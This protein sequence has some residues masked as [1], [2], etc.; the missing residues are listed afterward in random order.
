MIELR[1]DTGDIKNLLKTLKVLPNGLEKATARAINRTLTSTRAHMVKL[2]REDYAVKAGA[3]RSSLAIQK[4][5]WGNLTG[6]IHGAGPPGIPLLEFVRGSKKAP[7]TR[8]LKSGGYRPLVG[9]PVIVRKDKGKMPAKGVF[10]ARMKSGHV[11][12]F[13]RTVQ[14][15]GARRLT[16]LGNRYIKEAYGPSPLKIL[17]SARYDGQIEDFAEETMRKNLQHEAEY[18]LKQ[19]GLR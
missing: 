6:R 19:M 9:V 7:S 16:S 18:V 17:S 5:T 2:V 13:K 14:S 10:I 3:V 11:G 4:A 1:Y 8:R 12:A 15:S